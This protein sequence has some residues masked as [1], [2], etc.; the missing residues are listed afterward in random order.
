M[1]LEE[2]RNICYLFDRLSFVGLIFSNHKAVLSWG[3]VGGL[4]VK[5]R[6]QSVS[7]AFILRRI[8]PM[9]AEPPSIKLFG[10]SGLAKATVVKFLIP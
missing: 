6:G 1:M 10:L 4:S 2:C 8:D 7:R 3:L 9:V 5:K